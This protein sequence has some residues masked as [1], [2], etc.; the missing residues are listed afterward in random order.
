MRGGDSGVKS[1]P[2]D[3]LLLSPNARE[4]LWFFELPVN[5]EFI[6]IAWFKKKKKKAEVGKVGRSADV[7][8]TY[9]L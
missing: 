7:Q 9:V 6:K 4:S 1:V 2:D 8:G 5:Y 3:F